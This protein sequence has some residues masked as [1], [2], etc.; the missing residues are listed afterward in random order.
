[1]HDPVTCDPFNLNGLRHLPGEVTQQ[2][3]P[4]H[5]YLTRFSAYKSL[6]RNSL[7]FGL[8]SE[9][10]CCPH[11]LVRVYVVLPTLRPGRETRLLHFFQHVLP[12]VRDSAWFQEFGRGQSKRY[13]MP[14]EVHSI[15]V[16]F[17]RGIKGATWQ[18]AARHRKQREAP[19]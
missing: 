6:A 14:L 7:Q 16:N 10:W 8:V 13:L 15:R 2:S 1:M 18:Y 19:P 12:M 9:G 5:L 11:R 17:Q 3:R 4:L